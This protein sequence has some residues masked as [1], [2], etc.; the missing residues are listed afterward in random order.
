MSGGKSPFF[1][2]AADK[3]RLALLAKY[4][5]LKV[6]VGVDWE[7][8][9]RGVE[10]SVRKGWAGEGARRVYDRKGAARRVW[11]GSQQTAGW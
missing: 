3:K 11:D 10:Q 6:G 4:Q 2:K 9:E 8:V 1:L 5:E 7:G